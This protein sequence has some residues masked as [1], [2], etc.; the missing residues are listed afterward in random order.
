MYIYQMHPV[1]P[2]PYVSRYMFFK[3]CSNIYESKLEYREGNAKYKNIKID[4]NR[5]FYGGD[6][7]KECALPNK[8]NTKKLELTIGAIKSSMIKDKS[9]TLW[10]HPVNHIY[11]MYY[12]MKSVAD[13]FGDQDQLTKNLINGVSLEKFIDNFITNEGII[14]D[15][16]GNN[17]I[18]EFTKIS[19]MKEHTFVGCIEHI[20]DWLE[21]VQDHLKILIPKCEQTEYK[22]S[23]ENYRR[24]DLEKLLKD[25]IELFEKYLP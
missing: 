16:L 21:K 20:D 15:K 9:F 14:Y 19:K 18:P 23:K 17:L 2:Y 7:P 6:L 11:D 8:F 5:V 12:Y 24:N 4:S 22:E 10:Q 1:K 25:D 13:F 3:L